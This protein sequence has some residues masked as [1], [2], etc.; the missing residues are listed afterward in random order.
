MIEA[1]GRLRALN[2]AAKRGALGE[3]ASR[4]RPSHKGQLR[5]AHLDCSPPLSITFAMDISS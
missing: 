5:Y 3:C 2:R 4:A 1:L